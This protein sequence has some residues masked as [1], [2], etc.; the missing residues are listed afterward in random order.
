MKV[1]K[2]T[3]ILNKRS[4]FTYTNDDNVFISSTTNKELN[5]DIKKLGIKNFKL[6]I[7][8]SC[9]NK[10]EAFVII[11]NLSKKLIIT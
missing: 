11:K 2:I 4:F 9:L 3:N 7:I 8:C 10:K 1:F 6:K 5:S